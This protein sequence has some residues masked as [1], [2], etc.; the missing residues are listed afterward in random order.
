M[1]TLASFA[2]VAFLL[3][4]ASVSSAAPVYL[5][6]VGGW[7]YCYTGDAAAGGADFTALDGTWSHDNGSDQWD[8]TM[9]GAGRPGGAMALSENAVNFLRIQDTGDPRDYGM[10]DPGSNR[11][12]YFAQ[13]IAGDSNDTVLDD[14]ITITFRA[15]VA[16]TAPLDD[17]HPNGSGGVVPWPAGGDGHVL[18]DGGKGNFSVRQ[19]S[20][21][22]NVSFSLALA[23]DSGALNADGLVINN[24]NGNSRTNTVDTGE[25]PGTLNQL[26]LD[27]TQ[28]HEFWI[29]I[30]EDTTDTG[31]HLVR[32]WKD[33]SL[34][35][36]DFIVTAGD[37]SDY[38]D[39]YIGM[40]AG[41]T[42]S[43]CAYD[44]DFFCYKAGA[45]VAPEPATLGLLA[46]GAFGVLIRRKRR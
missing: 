43:A 35:S 2:G 31:T 5:P 32:V 12:I 16:T 38:D 15:R 23:S 4:T 40:G 36:D 17:G 28:W 8:E 20:G 14:G 46:I 27:P 21:D 45:V 30:E 34:V 1:R 7:D 24:L 42:D 22:M 19:S 6:P 3:A 9:I 39:S 13:L 25:T 44:I 29:T 18:H 11:K 37:G 26:V 10:G 33:G 41:Q